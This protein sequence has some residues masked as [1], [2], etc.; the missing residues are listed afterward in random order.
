MGSVIDYID[1]PNCGQEAFD[2]F[3]YK[4][5]EEYLFCTHCG[6]MKSS[7]IIARDKKLN[8][9]TETDWKLDLVDKPFGA[10]RI[11]YSETV[12]SEVGCLEFETEL[13][14]IK[15]EAIAELDRIEE[16]TLS[17]FIDGKIVETN[18]LEQLKNTNIL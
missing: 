12:A 7:T 8:E 18:I 4:T 14:K 11:K 6:Y 1:C 5:G 10:Y 3:Y 2:D 17:Q 9:L 15:S 16:F 13:D